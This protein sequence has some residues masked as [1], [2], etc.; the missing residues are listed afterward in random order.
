VPVVD[1][2]DSEYSNDVRQWPTSEPYGGRMAAVRCVA[3]HGYGIGATATPTTG[4]LTMAH[5]KT[6]VIHRVSLREPQKV[7][8]Q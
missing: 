1:N 7:K 5:M 6:T 3:Y 2:T 4:I 8:A